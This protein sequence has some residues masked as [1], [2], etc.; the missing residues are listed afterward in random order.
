VRAEV[1]LV[2]RMRQR[3]RTQRSPQP[4]ILHFLD[5]SRAIQVV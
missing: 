4:S 5:I 3:D 2:E 1:P